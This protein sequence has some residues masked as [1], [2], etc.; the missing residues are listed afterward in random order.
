MAL[1]CARRV[2]LPVVFDYRLSFMKKTFFTILLLTA[3]LAGAAQ[4]INYTGNGTSDLLSTSDWGYFW[5]IKNTAGSDLQYAGNPALKGTFNNGNPFNPADADDIDGGVYQ[6]LTTVGNRDYSLIFSGTE[7]ALTLN[8]AI[9]LDKVDVSGSLPTGYHINLGTEGMITTAQEM[10]F[11]ASTQF[12][13]L[14]VELSDANVSLLL[15]SGPVVYSRALLEA[16]SRSG[17]W[18]AGSNNYQPGKFDRISLTLSGA[19][20]LNLTE[21]ENLF[22]SSIDELGEGEYALLYDGST[23]AANKLTL[24]VKA[25]TPEPATAT[26]SLLAL[27]GLAA[28][29]KR[30]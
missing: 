6:A 28:R 25:Q 10:N 17:I 3:S 27:A 13:E 2:S 20:A 22:I 4:N 19:D 9:Y 18:N 23:N 30:H 11:G 29:R 26:L 16:K 21:H 12:I 7:C 24:V 5:N 15:E 1:Y 8:S 14:E